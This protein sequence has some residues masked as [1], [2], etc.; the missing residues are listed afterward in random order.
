[1]RKYV[2][3]F[4]IGAVL[5]SGI[6]VAAYTLLSSDVSFSPENSK[7]QVGNVED[8]LNSL[9]I[10]KTADDYS[11]DEKKIGTWIDGKPL[12]QKT[13][14]YNTATSGSTVANIGTINNMDTGFIID[15]FYINQ[16]SNFGGIGASYMLTNTGRNVEQTTYTSYFYISSSGI[17]YGL[18]GSTTASSKIVVTVRYTKTTD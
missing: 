14:V 18:F 4:I 1:M 15:G 3:W 10:A 2:I 11:T 6:G 9:Y 8:A 13:F 5:F 7:W 16:N 12:Y 17:I